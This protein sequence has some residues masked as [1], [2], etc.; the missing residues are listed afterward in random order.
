[1]K[2]VRR[3]FG[4]FFVVIG[5]FGLFEQPIA[6]LVFL[7]WGA[8]LLPSINR[9]AESK[10]VRL[11][12]W[13]RLCIV[14]VGIILVNVTTPRSQP[15]QL[16]AQ[17]VTPNTLNNQPKTSLSPT[18]KSRETS[19]GALIQKKGLDFSYETSGRVIE[20]DKSIVV[21][22]TRT[23]ECDTEAPINTV[24]Q[25]WQV[26]FDLESRTWT[27]KARDLSNCL[28]NASQKW[29]DSSTT[30]S[31]FNIE[32]NGNETIITV[33]AQDTDGSIIVK[34][35]LVVRYTKPI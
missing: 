17:Q 19:F 20:S 18:P 10:G 30:P 31:Q 29:I 33:D 35:A 23:S 22:Y 34:D 3:F 4:W 6:G 32:S 14:V 11:N 24:R 5:A 1:M 12:D 15:T 9:L 13:K 8:L 7:S 2:T 21:N 16:P 27:D 26:V 25:E 28:G